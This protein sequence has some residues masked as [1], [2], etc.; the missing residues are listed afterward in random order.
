MDL[1]YHSLILKTI[2]VHRIQVGPEWRTEN[3]DGVS[4]YIPWSR[5]YFPVSGEGIVTDGDR[6]YIL[7]P[8]MMLLIP[9]FSRSTV[10]CQKKLC[11]YWTHFNALLPGTSMDIFFRDGKCIETDVRDRMDYFTLLFDSLIRIEQLHEKSLIDYYEYDSYFRLLLAPFLRVLTESPAKSE[12]PKAIE[13]LRYIEINYSRKIT[14][15]ELAKTACMHPNYLSTSFHRR[16]NM[17][18]FEYIDRVRLHHALEYFRLG[19]MSISEIAERT[20]YSSLQAFSKNFRK[21]YGVSPR[22]YR[23]MEK[24]S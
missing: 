6:K 4:R 1:D 24:N 10:C 18:L 9:P 21:V 19:N 15:D 2:K 17:T 22:Q 20:G 23:T 12:L 8:G 7:K 14:L 3:F 5:I 11:K 16:M 13:L